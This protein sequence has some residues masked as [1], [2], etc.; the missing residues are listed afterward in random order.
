MYALSLDFPLFLS[1]IGWFV[2]HLYLMIMKCK[3]FSLLSKR[4][5]LGISFAAIPLQLLWL[6]FETKFRLHAFCGRIRDSTFLVCLF[7]DARIIEIISTSFLK[8]VYIYF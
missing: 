1:A 2:M 6:S 4:T 7:H 5:F 8:N 3:A